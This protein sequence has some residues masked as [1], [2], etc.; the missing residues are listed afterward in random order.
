MSD[1]SRPRSE[2]ETSRR[3]FFRQAAACMTTPLWLNAGAAPDVT[4]QNARETA[5][6]EGALDRLSGLAL[7]TNHG[8]MAA[9]AL[10]AL[11][12]AG[13]VG[14]W[15]EGYRRRFTNAFPPSH[16]AVTR[17]NWR[18]ALG[19]SRREADWVEFFTRELHEAS[20][21]HVVGKWAAE[22]APGLSAAAAH[23]LIRTAHAVRSLE[24]KETNLRLRELAAGL[25]YWAAYYQL[26]PALQPSSGVKPGQLR[27]AEAVKLI[28]H[29]PDE[30]RIH[31]NIVNGLRSLDRLPE[32]A[33]VADLTVAPAEAA[34][35]ISELTETF[36]TV[37]ARHAQANNSIALVHA[38]TGASALRT[39]LPYLSPAAT[40]SAVRFGWQLG[41][42][43]YS[44]YVAGPAK[45]LALTIEFKRDDLID[46]AVAT[47]DEHA[48]KFTE[49]C[50]REYALNP[51]PI[52]L[53]AA[54]DAVERFG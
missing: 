31:G 32:F 46:R 34:P 43:I 25:G 13:Q 29:L 10:V 37:Y 18:T 28:P 3:R 2:P 5:A 8:P 14:P 52:Y 42:A 24:A 26:L 15:V 22:L 27:P 38:V 33:Q 23:G 11:G 7:L 19:D 9:E 53:A 20:W 41:A 45:P 49:A 21:T 39:L 30:K 12:R 6:M 36:A 35:F 17:A 48:I 1:E 54:R 44:V 51:K 40:R 4:A 50:L 16:S 47:E